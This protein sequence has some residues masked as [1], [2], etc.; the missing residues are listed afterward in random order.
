MSLS[1]TRKFN[2]IYWHMALLVGVIAG[3][4]IQTQFNLNHLVA[5]GADITGH[6]RFTTSLHDLMRFTP[7]ML[8][9]LAPGFA[10]SQWVALYL[11]RKLSGTSE[12]LLCSIAGYVAL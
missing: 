3:S 9:L 10:L 2:L 6:L 11:A 8:V 4:L 12:L 5:M 1:S 7:T